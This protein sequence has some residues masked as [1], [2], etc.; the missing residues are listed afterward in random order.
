MDTSNLTGKITHQLQN[1]CDIPLRCRPDSI[2]LILLKKVN[3]AIG[4]VLY[5]STEF[6]KTESCCQLYLRTLDCWSS[7][8]KYPDNFQKKT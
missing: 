2:K 5:H 6:V 7:Y 4:A 8:W 1:I 3:V